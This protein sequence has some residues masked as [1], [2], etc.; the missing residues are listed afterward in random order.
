MQDSDLDH[1]VGAYAICCG[2]G[3]LVTIVSLHLS[4]CWVGV[5]AWVQCASVISVTLGIGVSTLGI[6]AATLGM[7]VACCAAWVAQT[8]LRIVLAFATPCLPLLFWWIA[9]WLFCNASAVLF[10]VG[11]FPWGAIVSWCGCNRVGF[12]WYGWVCDVLVFEEYCVT[13]LCC[14]CSC[15]VHLEAPVMFHWR[16]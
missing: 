2:T 7:C 10:P 8:L 6:G 16:A 3:G 5:T 9:C 12:R 14:P 11:M 13:D 15:Y 4:L 1:D